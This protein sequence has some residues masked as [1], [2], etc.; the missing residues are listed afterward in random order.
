[1]GRFI[2]P[3]TKR[4]D[5]TDDYH[6]T[7]VADPYRWLEDDVRTSPD[8]AEWVAAENKVTDAYLQADPGAGRDPQAA[9]RA[10]GT[11]RST[12]PRRRTAAATSTPRTTG[13]QNQ[14]VL[15]T[16]D[17]LDSTPR[18][19]LDPNTWSKD[20]TVA[21]AGI[22]HQRRR[23]ADRLRP[24]PRPA[25]TGTPGTPSTSTT[26]EPLPDELKW[27]KF[28]GASWTKDDKG[29]F[30]SRFPEPKEGQTFQSLNLNQKLY[31]H[32]L[33]TP[34]A[35]D[36]LVYTPTDPKYGRRRRPSPRTA[37]TCIIEVSDGTTSRK[38]KVFYKPIAAVR[39]AGQTL[40]DNF[41]N[42]WY[43]IG[44][45]GRDVLL[46]HRGRRPAWPGRRHRRPP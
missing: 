23:Q 45:D 21:L 38:S 8:V 16:A 25:A 31:Y 34:Q 44:N 22:G 27:I 29:F 2:I 17:E 19:L 33:G 18:M 1:M 35:E 46:P 43:F 4:I 32:R 36:Q 41:D 42:K 3:N 20:G 37:S 39:R 6:G 14:S 12:P 40:I 7:K 24:R 15:Y 10:L 9:D 26:G 13:L 5:H 28:T 30:Y 11:T